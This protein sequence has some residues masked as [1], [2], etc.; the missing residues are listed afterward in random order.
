MKNKRTKKL[1]SKALKQSANEAL[2]EGAAAMS[3]QTVKS[4]AQGLVGGA[5]MSQG[6]TS[7]KAR[8]KAQRKQFIKSLQKTK[9]PSVTVDP[10]EIKTKIL[11]DEPGQYYT[12]GTIEGKFLQDKKKSPN[13][14]KKESA[15]KM[16]GFSGFKNEK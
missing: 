14:I 1:V 2:L 13:K 15:F 4:L 3:G 10:K 12:P 8:R 7:R 5:L 16:K 9:K 6:A 11:K